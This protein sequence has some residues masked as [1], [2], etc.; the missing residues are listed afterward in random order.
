MLTELEAPPDPTQ[1]WSW[2]KILAWFP[3]ILTVSSAILLS[4]D[5]RLRPHEELL[6]H[7]RDLPD[8]SAQNGWTFLVNTWQT[9]PNPD[10]KARQ[11]WTNILHRIHG[12]VSPYSGT[13][14]GRFFMQ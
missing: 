5:E 8:D 13:L 12:T 10:P 7:R 4:Y 11:K 6:S 1:F 3:G 9:Y 14:P 2:K